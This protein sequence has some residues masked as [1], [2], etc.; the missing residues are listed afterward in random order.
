MSKK[1]TTRLSEIEL[2]NLLLDRLKSK[3]Q[4]RIDHFA[5]T[6][7]LTAVNSANLTEQPNLNQQV[8]PDRLPVE[9][10]FSH[11][12][13]DVQSRH[14]KRESFDRILFIVEGLAVVALL[15]IVFNGFSILQNLNQEFSL[16]LAQP[17]LTPTPLIAAVILPS[18]HTFSGENGG[19]PIPNESE[20]PEHL[21]PIVQ[22]LA[23]L[24]LP[25]QGPRQAIRIQIPSLN[26]DAPVVQGDG[27]EQLKKGVGQHFSSS[28]PGEDGNVILSA[29]ND[30]YGEIFRDLDKLESGDIIRVFTSQSTYEYTVYQTQVVDP[31]FIEVLNQTRNPII[32]LISCYPYGVNNQ[33]IIITGTLKQ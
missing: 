8:S 12:Q 30:I 20:I 5:A 7:T 18:G 28:N 6:G 9:T 13:D 32:T 17:N 21:K 27:W 25:T 16:A 31:T 1:E 14:G 4:A 24:P 23:E 22:S 3:R 29:H 15:F 19:V 33:R 2:R 10:E 26:I 11:S